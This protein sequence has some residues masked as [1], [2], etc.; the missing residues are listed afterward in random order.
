MGQLDMLFQHL[1]DNP[2]YNDSGSVAEHLGISP[3]E[4][5]EDLPEIKSWQPDLFLYQERN[6]G[7]GRYNIWI[8][9][10]L[11]SKAKRFL[12]KGGWVNCAEKIA[13]QQEEAARH[14]AEA[15]ARQHEKEEREAK[16]Q[17]LQIADWPK[18]QRERVITRWVAIA[19]ALFSLGATVVALIALSNDKQASPQTNSR[20]KPPVVNTRSVNNVHPV[21]K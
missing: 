1:I 15:A 5:E 11:E 12:A 9:E 20:P 14:A 6:N 4:L 10:R 8:P 21:S 13:I 17:E 18:M 19:A 3:E 2:G 16:L 7:Y